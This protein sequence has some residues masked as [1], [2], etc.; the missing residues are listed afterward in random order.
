MTNLAHVEPLTTP[1]HALVYGD[2]QLA[3]EPPAEI[4]DNLDRAVEWTIA[5]AIATPVIAAYGGIAYG[6]YLAA[7]AV[8]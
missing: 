5:V 1:E 2:G 6:L 3:Y 7:G 8:L 4:E